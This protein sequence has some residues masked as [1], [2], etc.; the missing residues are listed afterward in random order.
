M[1][2]ERDRSLTLFS[3][4][5]KIKQ[6]DYALVAAIN[7]ALSVG[8]CS[9]DGVVLASL[10]SFSPLVDLAH[11]MKIHNVCDTIGITYSG[12]Q[13]DFRVMFIKAVQLVEMYKDIYGRYPFVDVF[14]TEFSQIIQEHTQ[15]GGFR[16]FGVMLLVCGPIY[17][18]EA[19]TVPAMYQMDPSGSFVSIK[20]GAI[21]KDYSVSAKYIQNRLES[22]DDNIVTCLNAVMEN[23]GVQVKPGDVDIGVF[24]ASKK[25]FEVFTQQQMDEIFDSLKIK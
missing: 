8:A 17:S 22:L 10:K 21:G 12:L 20:S 13:P 4:E 1:N 24:D 9:A 23:S 7:G 15:K 25:T 14:V 16:P 5:G 19:G 2:F 6:C 18:K 11:V 3:S